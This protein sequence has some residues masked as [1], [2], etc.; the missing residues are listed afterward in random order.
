MTIVILPYVL[1][2]VI[3][4]WMGAKTLKS[5]AFYCYFDRFGTTRVP[6]GGGKKGDGLQNL[7]NVNFVNREFKI[8]T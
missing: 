3:L 2:I 8:K 4:M 6:P 7:E 5:L 1:R